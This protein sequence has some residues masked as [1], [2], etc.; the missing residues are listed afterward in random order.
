MDV[1]IVLRVYTRFRS[2]SSTKDAKTVFMK[3]A[4]VFPI[5]KSTVGPRSICP[6]T[7]VSAHPME[8]VIVAGK[9]SEDRAEAGRGSWR[10]EVVRLAWQI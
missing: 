3:H 10:R 9:V 8:R 4:L 5:L 2:S 6:L 1:H 7:C